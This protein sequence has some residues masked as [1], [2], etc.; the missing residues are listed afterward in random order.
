MNLNYANFILAT[1]N[2]LINFEQKFS[3]L[4]LLLKGNK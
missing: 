1:F 4:N 2:I 3:R